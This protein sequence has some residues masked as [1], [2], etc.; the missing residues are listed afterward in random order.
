VSR[1]HLVRRFWGSLS[2]REPSAPDIEWVEAQLSRAELELW[3]RMPVADRRHALGVAR[4]L[5]S[6]LGDDATRPV[7][8]A[9][10][11]H[12]VGKVES[13]LST[14]G[15]VIA[16]LSVATAGR[17]TAAAWGETNGVTRRVGL[18]ARHE[19]LGADMLELAGSDPVTVD[20]LR[21]HSWDDADRTVD[22]HLSAALRAADD[23]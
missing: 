7:L 19:S 8:A 6:A 22:A 17:A 16:T 10:L 2:R 12:D 21:Q 9:G 14:Y 18:Y 20:L 11:L 15:R 4:R 1:G 13:G 3:A 5:E 23:A